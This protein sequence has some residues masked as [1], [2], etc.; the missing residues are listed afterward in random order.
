MLVLIFCYSAACALP[1]NLSPKLL[2]TPPH[3]VIRTCCAFGSDLQLWIIPIWKYTAIS[4]L[5]E[6]G[7]HGYLGN[8]A[9]GNGIIYTRRGGFID[10]GHMRDEAD[11]TAY[12]YSRIEMAKGKGKTLIHLGHEGGSKDLNLDIPEE[13]STD[14]AIKLAGRIAYD[15][16]VWHEIASWYG[17]S[18]IPFVPE[19][20][21][22]F[23]IEDPYSNLMGATLGMEAI[24]STLP[25]EEAMSQIIHSTMVILGASVTQK[26]TY[27]AMEAVRDIWWT[28]SKHLPDRRIMLERQMYVYGCQEPWLIPGWSTNN[29]PSY[30]LNVPE[31]TVDG[32][33]LNNYY[34]LEFELNFKFPVK[35]IFA[36]KNHRRATQADFNQFISH[37]SKEM[38]SDRLH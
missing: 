37:I 3:R 4:G 17:C 16:S 7:P 36:S 23:S 34:E 11:W 24:K 13:I 21:S 15:L 22:S 14:D 8:S 33:P 30:D 1:P 28:R 29:L 20:Y 10:M 2:A 5:D 32:R 25:Y 27:N 31:M 26:E 9:E 12:L 35:E 38:E 19:R 6:L 18:V